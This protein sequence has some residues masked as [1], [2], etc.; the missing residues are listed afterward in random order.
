MWREEVLGG[1]LHS[2]QGAARLGSYPAHPSPSF[3][4]QLSWC[5]GGCTDAPRRHVGPAGRGSG[6][7]F[8]ATRSLFQWKACLC[9][10]GLVVR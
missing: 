3:G 8:L 7:F 6:F 5:S 2:G 9:K 4:P 1:G 10:P